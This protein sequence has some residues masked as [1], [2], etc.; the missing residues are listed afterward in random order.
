MSVE[1]RAVSPETKRGR[2]EFIN[3]AWPIYA[4]IPNWVPPLKVDLHTMLNPKKHPYH[5]HA[6]AQL[7]V[8]YRD[9]KAAGRI[10][11]HI[12]HEHSKRWNQG[13]G[14]FGFYEAE[15]SQEIAD[16][17]FD[18]AAGFV[19]SYGCTTLRGPYSWSPND[20]IGMLIDSFDRDPALMMP[21]NPPYYPAQLE[22][23]GFS[24]AKD[25]FAY[26]IEDPGE[27]PER[28]RRGVE[29]A[30][31][32]NQVEIRPF[33]TK[34]FWDEVETLK[35]LYNSAW[36]ANWDAVP[37]SDQEIEHLA[38]DLKTIL[39]PEIVYFAYVR[40]ELAGFALSLPDANQA[41][42]AANGRLLPIGI[43]KI[44]RGMKRISH[45]RVLLLGLLPHYRNSG[46]DIALYHETFSRG[47]ARGYRSAEMSWI[48]EDNYAMR[49]PLE[50]F[51]ARP[52]KTY[53]IYDRPI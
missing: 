4:G 29:I 41:M 53:R 36:E 21:Y 40:G 24:K 31:K 47:V 5:E 34:K 50:K 44:M 2:S 26:W 42:K 28:L 1:V 25:L 23:A 8:A 11:A 7:F 15:E 35:T 30:K 6:Q 38:K 16:A 39:D 33:N 20:E 9:G 43:F 49:N 45:I 17:L 37:M 19:K 12:N 10:A 27:I 46:V 22:Q 14:F 51:G 48:L 18:A 32:R 52:F 13:V 3:L